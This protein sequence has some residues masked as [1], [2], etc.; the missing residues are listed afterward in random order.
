METF[1]TGKSLSRVPATLNQ[2]SPEA[3]AKINLLIST[4]KFADF[5]LLRVDEMR[6]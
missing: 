3:P 2:N 5:V 1:D 4:E 6:A